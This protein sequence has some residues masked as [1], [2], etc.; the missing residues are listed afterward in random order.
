M[1]VMP[2]TFPGMGFGLGCM[3][4][5]DGI[6]KMG[7]GLAMPHYPI[8]ICFQLNVVLQDLTPCLQLFKFKS[9]FGSFMFILIVHVHL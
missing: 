5:R 9:V 1:L 4:P 8:V 2:R 6:Q 3:P 7:S